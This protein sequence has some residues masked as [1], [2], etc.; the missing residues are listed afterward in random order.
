MCLVIG[1]ADSLIPFQWSMGAR[2]SAWASIRCIEGLGGKTAN[3]QLRIYAAGNGSDGS[4]QVPRV[5][6]VRPWRLAVPKVWQNK[7][8]CKSASSTLVVVKCAD[9]QQASKCHLC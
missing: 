1:Y 6:V 2:S 3:L 4:G 8:S 9:K 7:G 5:G